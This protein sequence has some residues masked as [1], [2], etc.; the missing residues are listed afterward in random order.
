MTHRPLQ[1]VI[2]SKAVAAVSS[3][4]IE[5]GAAV[6]EVKNDYGEDL[7]VQTSLRGTVDA[8]R[9]WVQVKGRQKVAKPRAGKDRTVAVAPNT[10]LRWVNNADAMVIVLW[11]VARGEGWY[12]Y[13][14]HQINS[15]ELFTSGNPRVRIRFA[16]E[17]VFNLDTANK[18]TWESRI[19][20]ANARLIGL[21]DQESFLRGRERK[22]AAEIAHREATYLLFDFL[23]KIGVIGP[24]GVDEKIAHMVRRCV[25]DF[26]LKEDPEMPLNNALIEASSFVCLGEID[27]LSRGCG[28]P[29][30]LMDDL[31]TALANALVPGGPDRIP[32][33][34]AGGGSGQ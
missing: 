27:A 33:F 1:H 18:I 21:R 15:Y 20:H 24:E 16:S 26:F 11:D 2:A 7:L 3:V 12:A 14:R 28:L 32:E 8:S 25:N 9:I 29:Y 10:A 5:L 19:G 4:W 6:E 23:M 22:G 13:P 17:N 30:A 31:G 34:L